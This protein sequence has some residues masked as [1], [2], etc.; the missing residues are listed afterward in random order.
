MS[1]RKKKL[2]FKAA[3]NYPAETNSGSIPVNP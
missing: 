3:E 1:V 2:A